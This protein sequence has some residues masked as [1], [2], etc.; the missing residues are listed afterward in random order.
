MVEV[1]F[2]FDLFGN[3]LEIWS[4]EYKFTKFRVKLSFLVFSVSFLSS[5]CM[6]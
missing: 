1:D 5:Q 3:K 2:I 4:N 6:P